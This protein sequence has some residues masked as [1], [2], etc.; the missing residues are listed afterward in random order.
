MALIS[1]C[2]LSQGAAERLKEVGARLGLLLGPVLGFVEKSAPNQV[3]G[4]INES[5]PSLQVL[6]S[7]LRQPSIRLPVGTEEGG[8]A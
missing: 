5:L 7:L 6:S 8:G 2:T 3:T 4:P 1:Q